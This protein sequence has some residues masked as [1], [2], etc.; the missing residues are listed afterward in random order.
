MLLLLSTALRLLD[1]FVARFIAASFS[2]LAIYLEPRGY[3]AFVCFSLGI[4]DSRQLANIVALR[5]A[6]IRLI[7]SLY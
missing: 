4:V 2:R 1:F 3:L 7:S 6:R 5:Y